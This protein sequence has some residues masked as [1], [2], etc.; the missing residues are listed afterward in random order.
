MYHTHTLFYR[1]KQ[2][3]THSIRLR[4]RERHSARERTCQIEDD[5]DVE[6]ECMRLKRQHQLDYGSSLVF[7]LGE[8]VCFLDYGA[9]V[10]GDQS[11][12]VC[13]CGCG[14]VG[15][16]GGVGVGVYAF[17]LWIASDLASV[18][19]ALRIRL[20]RFVRSRF[21]FAIW[22]F[23]LSA[24]NIENDRGKMFRMKVKLH[25]SHAINDEPIVSNFHCPS[26]FEDWTHVAIQMIRINGTTDNNKSS[27]FKTNMTT[28]EFFYSICYLF[29]FFCSCCDE[30]NSF[31][32]W[33][34]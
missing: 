28:L 25:I 11:I 30:Q 20:V 29:V 5:K 22:H 26:T 23:R 19:I 15:V 7:E 21:D 17:R 32:I 24:I 13:A 8:N 34:T 31:G 1:I 27:N 6:S 16:D 18:F 33:L 14:C 3:A 2:W 12:D 10:I 4:D 9:I